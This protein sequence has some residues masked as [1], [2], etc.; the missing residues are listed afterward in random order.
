MLTSSLLILLIPRTHHLMSLLNIRS[1][2]TR[3][4]LTSSPRTGCVS[5]LL[6]I[7]HSLLAR[8]YPLQRLHLMLH[9]HRLEL[10][11]VYIAILLLAL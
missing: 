1:P 2:R 10:C 4:R 6:A 3:S 9:L 11:G 7:V 5:H 8:M